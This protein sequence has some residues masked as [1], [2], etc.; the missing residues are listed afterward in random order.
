MKELSQYLIEAK[1]KPGVPNEFDNEYIQLTQDYLDILDADQVHQR[2]LKAIQ[3]T[4][5]IL[6]KI[7]DIIGIDIALEVF[8]GQAIGRIVE[9]NLVKTMNG[10]AGFKFFHGSENKNH[11]DLEC[12]KIGKSLSDKYDTLKVSPS[13]TFDSKNPHSYGIELKFATTSNVAGNKAYVIDKPDENSK[14]DKYSFYILITNG[15][16]TNDLQISLDYDASFCYLTQSDWEY[17]EKGSFAKPH[18]IE[19]RLIKIY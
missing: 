11:K 5:K 14:K 16:I 8:K 19:D 2:I 18:V 4:N 1:K 12:E 6:A 9:Y 3:E 13:N 10:C 7:R 17:G 15:K